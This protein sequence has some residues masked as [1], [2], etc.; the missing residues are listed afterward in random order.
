MARLP[1]LTLRQAVFKQIV[2]DAASRTERPAMFGS[3]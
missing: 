3:I 1:G 2:L